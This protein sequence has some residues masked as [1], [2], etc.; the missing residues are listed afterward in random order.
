[1]NTYIY[2]RQVHLIFINMTRTKKEKTKQG[3]I[4]NRTGPKIKDPPHHTTKPTSLLP[5]PA[6]SKKEKVSSLSLSLSTPTCYSPL[7]SLSFKTQ[8]SFTLFLSPVGNS[9]E[10]QTTRK[11][12]SKNLSIPVVPLRPKSPPPP[13][14]PPCFTSLSLLRPSRRRHQSHH[15][16]HN[17][18]IQKKYYL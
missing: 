6:C 17:P 8:I 9:G 1:M 2:T 4:C 16:H 14:M 7:L 5:S 3:D 10:R 11:R 15:P 13:Y 18:T 12:E